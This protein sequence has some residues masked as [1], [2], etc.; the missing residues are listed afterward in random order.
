MDV[1]IASSCIAEINIFYNVEF[2]F[3]AD[4][5]ENL[6][7]IDNKGKAHTINRGLYVLSTRNSERYT[8]TRSID[9]L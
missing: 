1:L 2:N 6:R 8:S 5:I 3:S 7:V 9:D 4:G